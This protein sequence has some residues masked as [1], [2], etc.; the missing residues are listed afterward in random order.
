MKLNKNLLILI[1]T[2]LLFSCAEY[3]VKKSSQEQNKQYFSSSGF[4][5]IYDDIF[6]KDKT[7]NKKINN[8]EIVVMHSLLKRNTP[9][10]IINP[11]NS[12]IIETKIHKTA[13]YPYLFNAVVSNKVAS[14]LELDV[15]DPYV[16]I[17]EVKKN[18]TFVAK[19]GSIFE[20][21]KNVADKVPVNE[22]KMDDLSLEKK[23]S[24]DKEKK[25]KYLLVISDFYYIDSANSLKNELIEKTSL[26]NIFVKKINDNKY[27][28]LVGP[29]QNFNALK[30][31]IISLNNLGFES[32]NIYR[33]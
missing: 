27:R 31:S 11:L 9:I 3:N 33:E 4:V 17:I 1:L 2:F 32:L 20:E 13:K 28:L 26:D 8:D 6:Y 10:K 25:K 14:I 29:F 16:E 15:N 23:K 21:E 18:K 24:E 5:L 19:E 30:S 22:V 7:V 12:K